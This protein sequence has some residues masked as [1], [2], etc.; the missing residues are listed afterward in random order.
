MIL[1]NPKEILKNPKMILK[2][3]KEILKNLKMILKNPKEILKKTLMS[4]L[5]KTLK[6]QYS[7]QPGKPHR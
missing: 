5:K 6:N 4:T 2:N 3:P 1:K 7:R